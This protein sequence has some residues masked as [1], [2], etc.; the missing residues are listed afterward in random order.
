MPHH[1]LGH[2][3][4]LSSR[5]NRVLDASFAPP[6]TMSQLRASGPAEPV[7]QGHDV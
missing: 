4:A 2:I 5:A 6:H 1:D 3:Q 7:R